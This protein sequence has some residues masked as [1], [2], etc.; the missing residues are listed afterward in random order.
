MGECINAMY[1][2]KAPSQNVRSKK[3]PKKREETLPHS[4]KTRDDDGQPD[5]LPTAETDWQYL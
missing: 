2:K 4:F 5:F 3:F 1:N